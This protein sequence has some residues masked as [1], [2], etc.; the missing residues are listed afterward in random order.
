MKLQSSVLSISR[1]GIGKLEP[2]SIH[3]TAFVTQSGLYEFLCLPF[4]LK[5]SAASFQRLK[6]F[7]LKDL[8]G[9]I[10]FVCTDDIV[11]YSKNEKEHPNHL[12][13]VLQCLNKAG[14]TL[15]LQKCNLMQRPLK[16]LGHVMSAEGIK[17]DQDKVDAVANF[18]VP[19]S[20]KEVQQFLGLAGWYQRFIPN[21]SEKAASLHPLK[22]QEAT[23]M[24]TEECQNSFELIK[25]E[26]IHAPILIAPDL[27]KSF[28]VQT[29][30]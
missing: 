25:S 16:F 3:K 7:V 21:F 26:L 9:K 12:K 14:L 17:T 11:V 28:K 13:E 27:S 10:C 1:V 22:R 19:K 29:D 23:W 15:T 18:P 6:E 20:L 5:N 24:W 30:A 8:K 2:G 4:G